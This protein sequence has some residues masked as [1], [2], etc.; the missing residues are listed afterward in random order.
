MNKEESHEKFLAIHAAYDTLKD[1]SRRRAYDHI[2]RPQTKLS[3][4]AVSGE[5]ARNPASTKSACR[6]NWRRYGGSRQHLRR[7]YEFHEE[8]LV[9]KDAAWSPLKDDEDL[10][11]LRF[12]IW[13]L[14]TNEW[15]VILDET[16]IPRNDMPGKMKFGSR[17]WEDAPSNRKMYRAFNQLTLKQ[18]EEGYAGPKGLLQDGDHTQQL[19]DQRS[20]SCDG[21][22]TVEPS[23]NFDA[24]E[25][26][27]PQ[28]KNKSRCPETYEDLTNRKMAD[29]LAEARAIVIES[30]KHLKVI[31]T[32]LFLLHQMVERYTQDWKTARNL[33]EAKE[34]IAELVCGKYLF[35]A[36][37]LL[38]IQSYPGKFVA[39][40]TR[41]IQIIPRWASHSAYPCR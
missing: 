22:G 26:P 4:A 3:K 23:T 39:S 34:K 12:Y 15:E 37:F 17:P 21:S 1:P 6:K 27:R 36:F 24:V 14:I 19:L 32:D 8:S 35:V 13:N 29:Q 25:P 38:P 30:R 2:L 18:Y 10:K 33:K 20:R 28:T 7:A 16:K 9:T 40:T 31:W 41:G 11:I 5:D